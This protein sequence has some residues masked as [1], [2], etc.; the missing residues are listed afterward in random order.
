MLSSQHLEHSSFGHLQPL[1]I[2]PLDRGRLPTAGG[3]AQ[4]ACWIY[5][6][7]TDTFYF[8]FKSLWTG[9]KFWRMFS[10]DTIQLRFIN[11]LSRLFSTLHYKL[12]KP[13]QSLSNLS[14]FL[15]TG[16][17]DMKNILFGV[18]S[19]ERL[20]TSHWARTAISQARKGPNIK[21]CTCNLENDTTR[22]NI[23][24]LNAYS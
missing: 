17:E 14:I 13:S 15:V 9:N 1:L 8:I 20:P 11:L 6:S 24:H 18:I 23:S 7:L 19:T 2:S 5:S 22:V 16:N 4:V 10:Q 21:T 12:W 3:P